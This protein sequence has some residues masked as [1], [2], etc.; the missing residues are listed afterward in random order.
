M[1]MDPGELD[2]VAFG[3][4]GYRGIVTERQT[5]QLGRFDVAVLHFRV[6]YGMNHSLGGAR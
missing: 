6:S 3:R 5:T 2:G 4:M 1:R